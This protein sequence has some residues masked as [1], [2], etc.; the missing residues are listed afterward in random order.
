MK[1]LQPKSCYCETTV[2]FIQSSTPSWRQKIAQW[3]QILSYLHTYLF[4]IHEILTHMY[5]KVRTETE[6]QVTKSFWCT[7]KFLIINHPNL[8][9]SRLLSD[10]T[11]FW[12]HLWFQDLQNFEKLWGGGQFL[13]GTLALIQSY[14]VCDVPNVRT[15][16]VIT[17][18][19]R[20]GRPNGWALSAPPPPLLRWD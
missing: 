17:Q 10:A 8:S 3:G 4:L 13:Q 14:Y 6:T 15:R 19:F 11:F 2:E 9:F 18:Y 5:V 7:A 16:G 12:P 1:S 20:W